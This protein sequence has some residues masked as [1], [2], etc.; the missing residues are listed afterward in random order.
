MYECGTYEQ[1]QYWAN[2]FDDFAASLVGI[3]LNF[4]RMSFNVMLLQVVLWDVMVVNNWGVFLQAFK[5]E[6]NP[7]SQLF[8][9]AWWLIS[10][11]VCINLFVALILDH[12]IAKW[13]G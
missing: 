4:C 6:V 7:W 8:F 10:S 9:V 13:E 11:V 1:L 2:N 3:F 5:R 12:F